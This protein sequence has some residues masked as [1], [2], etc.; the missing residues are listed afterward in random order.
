MATNEFQRFRLRPLADF[1]NI[2]GANVPLFGCSA[3][4][5]EEFFERIGYLKECVQSNPEST[6]D[7][8]YVN[9]ELFKASAHRCLELNGI[10]V[11]DVGL[12]HLV[13]L[14][15]HEVVD[16]E[17]KPGLLVRINTPRNQ[18]EQ[19]DEIDSMLSPEA[20]QSRY[21]GLIAALSEF[22]ESVADAIELTQR[23]TT[24]QLNAFLREKNRMAEKTQAEAQKAAGGPTTL[25]D[26]DRSNLANLLAKTKPTK[27]AG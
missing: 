13:D 23:M 4:D 7:E 10:R 26:A 6:L 3:A 18:I 14:L 19:S 27:A 25:T 22:T 12:R 9:D 21:E 2:R 20:R 15:L 17:L 1:I 16:G 24:D 5:T 8:L 11:G